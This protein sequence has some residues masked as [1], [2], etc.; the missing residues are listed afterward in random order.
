M[1]PLV[2]V[3]IP[4]F[5]RAQTVAGAI[6]SCL[7]QTYAH[8]EV[9]LVD[10]GSVD[11]IEGAVHPFAGTDKIRLVRH[12]RNL[13]VSAARNTGVRDAKGMYV[14]FLDSDDAWLPTKLERQVAEALSRNDDHFI[15]GTLTRVV[16]DKAGDRI[17]PKRRPAKGVPIGD[18]LFVDSVQR[19]LQP[20]PSQGLPLIGGCF[21]QTSSYLLSRRLAKE[22]PFRVGL[23]QYEDMA[24][25]ID[26]GA[27][28]ADFLLVEEPLTIQHDDDRPGRL[29]ARD[30]VARGRQFLEAIGPSLSPDARLAYEATHLAHLYWK[31]QPLRMLTVVSRAFLRRAIAPRSVLGILSRSLLG[32]SGQKTLRNVL[33]KRWIGPQTRQTT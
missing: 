20:V 27:K 15:S 14:A 13:G 24:F 21:A 9:I 5:N 16:S 29:G 25:L 7:V 6:E 18:Y 26:L 28:G 17:R 19:S 32:Q 8:I 11:D 2:S 12:E 3:I 22:T 33:R 1:D 31:K 23:N 4:V 30:D 10:D